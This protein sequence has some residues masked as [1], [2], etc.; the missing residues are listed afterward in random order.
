MIPVAFAVL[1]RG[2]QVHWDDGDLPSLHMSKDEA[3]TYRNVLDSF[4]PQC[5]VHRIVTLYRRGVQKKEG[6]R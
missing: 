3:Q 1:C 5:G 2:G 6:K 4:E